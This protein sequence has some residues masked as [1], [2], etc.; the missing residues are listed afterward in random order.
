MALQIVIDRMNDRGG[1]R[2]RGCS[3]HHGRLLL[4]RRPGGRERFGSLDVARITTGFANRGQG[5]S[6]S[7]TLIGVAELG[8]ERFAPVS[9]D[10]AFEALQ[11]SL[12]DLRWKT[13]SVN[14]TTKGLNFSTPAAGFSWGGSWSAS[15]LPAQGGSTVRIGGASRISSSYNITANAA[16][17]K[18]LGKLLDRFG[19]H[20]DQMLASDPSGG[21]TLTASSSADGDSSIADQL[22][23]LADLHV[24]GALSADEFAAAKAKIIG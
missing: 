22:A 3:Q 12:K 18:Q 19:A 14:D 24:S 1:D 11:R 16:E 2:Q 20:V 4:Q 10:W 9:P 15:V 21:L 8:S 6:R 17:S 13:K 23:K 5:W 7:H